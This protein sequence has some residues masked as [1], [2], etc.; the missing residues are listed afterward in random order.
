VGEEEEGIRYFSK[1]KVIPVVEG[2]YVE[3]ISTH[4]LT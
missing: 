1:C 2:E 4:T 3:L